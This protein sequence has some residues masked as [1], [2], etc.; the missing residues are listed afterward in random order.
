MNAQNVANKLRLAGIHAIVT[1]EMQE[2]C[3][4]EITLLPLPNGEQMGVQVSDDGALIVNTYRG[5]HTDN[6]TARHHGVTWSIA[7]LIRL[8]ETVRSSAAK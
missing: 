1:G 3:D 7:G 5:E 6:F 8:I 2:E 4:A